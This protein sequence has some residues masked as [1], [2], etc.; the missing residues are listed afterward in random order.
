MYAVVSKYGKRKKTPWDEEFFGDHT[1]RP[2]TSVV[3]GQLLAAIQWV[4]TM[5][6][7]WQA[8][9]DRGSSNRGPRTL[10]CELRTVVR[11]PW[12]VGRGSMDS[13]VGFLSKVRVGKP[14]S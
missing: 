8:V 14:D 6:R 7:C 1:F 10:G 2:T 3:S 11:G 9:V 5:P 12:A 13:P 4:V